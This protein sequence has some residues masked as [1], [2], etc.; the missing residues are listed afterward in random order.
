MERGRVLTGCLVISIVFLFVL[1]FT[2][3][4]VCAATTNTTINESAQATELIVKAQVCLS[5][6]IKLG[7][8]YN[9][10][11]SSLQDAEQLF[12]AQRA[13]EAQRRKTSYNLVI[14]A[15]TSVCTVKNSAINA[16]EQLKVFLDSYNEAAKTTN[17]SG[18]DDTYN[19][20]IN[21]FKE[22]RFEDTLTAIKT[23]YTKVSEIQSQQTALRL[24]YDTTSRTIKNFFVNNWKKI[25]I[26]GGILIVLLIIFW[27]VLRRLLIGVKV[28]NLNAQKLSLNSLIKELQK[29]YFSTGKISESEYEVKMNRFKE[30]MLDIE[31]QIPLLEEELAKLGEQNYFK[32]VFG[33]KE[34]TKDKGKRNEIRV[35]E[36]KVEP[37]K[38]E[39]AIHQKIKKRRKLR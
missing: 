20:I 26:I 21:S 28:R 7:I 29:G 18:M 35:R 1:V 37:S 19:E 12:L 9:R 3:T 16:D 5:D 36:V 13:L 22:E 34:A 6:L 11:N 15:A 4:G 2:S 39:R 38:R 17:L 25:S 33:R 27:R 30:M 31:R 32:D 14:D 23:G 24:F 10:T 8:P